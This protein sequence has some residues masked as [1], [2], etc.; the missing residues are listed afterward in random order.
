MARP[1]ILVVSSVILFT[2][3]AF[4]SSGQTE[5]PDSLFQVVRLLAEQKAYSQAIDRLAVLHEQYPKNT[6]YTIYLARLYFWSGSPV[7]VRE[8]VSPLVAA[9]LPNE[10]ALLLLIQTELSE[11]RYTDV[12]Q[13]CDKGILF[14]PAT[15]NNYLL[16][17]ATALEKNGL[18]DDALAL[19]NT[20]PETWERYSDVI[21]L[22]NQILRKQPNL[23]SISYINTSFS[24]P[25]FA[26][27]HLAHLEYMR[28]TKRNAYA[29]RVTYG[30]LFGISSVQ[31]EIDAY[32]K[33][34]N[35]SYIYLNTGASNGSIFP[36]FRF[37][38]EFFQD[39]KRYSLSAGGRYLHFKTTSVVMFTGHFAVQFSNW[40]ATYRPFLTGQ[41]KSWLLSHTATV[42]R[43]FEKTE[44]YVQLDLQY[45][46]M[47]YY[48]LSN[49]EFSRIAAYRA[50]I[51]CRFRMDNHIFI[52]P[53][54]M[55]EREEFIPGT[56][57]NRYTV[58]LILSKRF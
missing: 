52:Q 9:E 38:S 32:P 5:N 37:G 42:R 22:K 6:D 53:V 13:L 39:L 20:I 57:R 43:T 44:S 49:D 40:K 19:L 50:G 31:G 27:W 17:K 28:K 47:P 21:Y 16:N 48:L 1:V 2:G 33:I 12:I 35:R 54:F 56:F 14:F 24:H 4:R 10:E 46:G 45:G 11:E 7:Q 51:N 29:A 58:Q 23:L 8:M 30:S 25:G 41:E 15:K 55:Y 26:P 3:I 36:V 34:G 18:N